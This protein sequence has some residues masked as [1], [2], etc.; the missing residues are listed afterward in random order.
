MDYPCEIVGRL[1]FDPPRPNMKRN[2]ERWAVVTLDRELTRYYRW[3]VKT[4]YHVPLCEPS[5]N[6]HC[7]AIRGERINNPSQ[8]GVGDGK[9]VIVKYS[10]TPVQI[11]NRPEM[12]YLPAQCDAISEL[13]QSFGLKTFYDYHITIGR[14]YYED[15][16]R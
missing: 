15:R 10:P 6:A 2:T 11:P 7:S 1:R 13:R 8:W 4:V 5:W 12:W 16:K 14:L 3:W 9:R